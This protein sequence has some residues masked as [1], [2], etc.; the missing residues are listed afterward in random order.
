VI[1]PGKGGRFPSPY[2]GH[3]AVMVTPGEC[4]FYYEIVAVYNLV[5]KCYFISFLTEKIM[6]AILFVKPFTKKASRKGLLLARGKIR[7][8]E[9]SL[10]WGKFPLIMPV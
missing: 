6:Q 2:P 5:I 7:R 8:E 10:V 3:Q 1:I 4:I 9:D